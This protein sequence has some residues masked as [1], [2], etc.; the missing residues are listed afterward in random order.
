MLITKQF[1]AITDAE[2]IDRIKEGETD[3][4]EILIRRNNPFLYKIGRSYGYN[5]QDVEDLMQET[6]I[7]AYLNLGKFKQHSS[8]KTWIIKIMLNQCYHKAQRLSFKNE[9]TIDANNEREIPLFEKQQSADGYKKI[10]DR[11]FNQVIG[12]AV[13][14]IPLVYRIAFSLRELN[15]L[16]T[17]ETA[18]VLDISEINVKVRLSRARQLLRQKIEKMYAS[19]DIFEFNLIYCD[20]VVNK[21][22][23]A[24]SNL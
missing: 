16:S 5:H 20:S 17:T 1:E 4:F 23:N 9:E 8:F 11:E 18:E 19:E 24:I 22:M 6:F 21:V 2:V 15:G 10:I 13:A 3:L 14:N 7:A 12:E